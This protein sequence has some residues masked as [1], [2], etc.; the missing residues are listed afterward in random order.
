[1]RRVVVTGMGAITPIGLSVDEFWDGVK[2]SKVGI[3]PITQFDATDFKAKIA[4]EVK[5][6]VG[7]D[8]M[9][10]KAAKRMER[11]SQFAVAAAKE[12]IEQ[13]GL[14]MSK[15]DPYMVGTAVGSGTG[16]L[17]VIERNKERL[18]TKGPSRLEPLMIPLMISNMAAGNVSIMFGLK[19]K[20]INVV[21][22]CATS[23]H[24]IGE[25]FRTIQYGDADVMLAGGTE[26]CVTPIGIGGFNALTALNT[27]E[28][29]SRASIPFDKDRAGFV[30]GEGAG[31]VVL[32]ELEHAKARGA[33]ILAEVVGY[34]ST[35]DAYHITSPAEDG[36]GAAK[37]M[38]NAMKDAGVSPSEVSYINAH[39]T[40]THH[41][42]LFETRAIKVALGDVAEKVP[43]SSTKSMVGHLLGAA[44]G[45]EFITC[46]KSIEEGYI[47]ENVGLKNVD[48]DP[49]FTLNYVK[50][51]GIKADVDVCLS[52][53]LGFGGHN[54]TLAVRKY[55]G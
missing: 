19:G 12:A 49:D 37:A 17:Q 31:I 5:D 24:N 53:S 16:A 22:A 23:T 21:T 8:Y 4:A 38:M 10:P 27:T 41:N 40:S 7:K 13:A 2:A 32:E 28:D 15:E 29:C 50:D 33:K 44:G 14:D 42:D 46:V 3:G 39:G 6:F 34:G 51:N 26:A 45:V 11:F 18:E 25:A 55:N 48:D 47:H 20:S 9:D 30:L 1:M 35:S 43:V 36:M 52:N 54:A